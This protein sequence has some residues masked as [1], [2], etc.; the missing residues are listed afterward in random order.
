MFTVDEALARAT[1][2]LGPDAIDSGRLSDE[3]IAL[4]AD[5]F[6]FDYRKF[7]QRMAAGNDGQTVLVAH[8]YLDH[9]VGAL[10]TEGLPS[11]DAL[12]LERMAFAQKLQLATALD[13][14]RPPEVAMLTAVNKI[15]NR[16]AHELEFEVDADQVARLRSATP[17]ELS[18]WAIKQNDERSLTLVHLL[19]GI[20]IFMEYRRQTIKRMRMV[21]RRN[22]VQM[23]AV[24]MEAQRYLAQLGQPSTA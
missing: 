13:L 17:S 20:V 8:L 12:D 2:I 24:M 16:L 5:Q 6:S 22:E 1:G 14:T 18:S 11:S 10:L 3:D 15:R 4:I 23:A 21:Q 19:V 7:E 9:I